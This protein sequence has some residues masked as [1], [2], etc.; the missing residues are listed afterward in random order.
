VSLQRDRIA[1]LEQVHFA[2]D[3]DT[4]LPESLELLAQ[5]AKVLVENPWV[6]KVRVEGHTDSK[7]S[8]RHNLDL[9][10]RRAR[11]V[12]ERLVQSG[13]APGRLESK[14]YGSSRP[15]DTNASD[16]GRTRNRRVVFVILAQ[17]PPG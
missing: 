3:R 7:G 4:I 1:L 6:L 8:T 15:V 12:R 14:G 10:G 11:I 2:N 16:A 5:V 9:S 17:E 13:V